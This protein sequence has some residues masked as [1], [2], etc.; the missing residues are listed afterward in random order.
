[1]KIPLLPALIIAL[2]I[3]APA[4]AADDAPVDFKKAHEYFDRRQRG[5]KLTAE[6]EA[7]VRRAI[8]EEKRCGTR[9]A[10]RQARRLRRPMA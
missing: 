9:R 10:S 6:E 1:M 2:S 3:G 5:E 8:A 7:Y 4:F